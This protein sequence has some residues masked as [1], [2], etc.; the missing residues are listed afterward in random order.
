MILYSG[1]IS[2]LPK[3]IQTSLAFQI[4]SSLYST[5]YLYMSIPVFHLSLVLETF[6]EMESF[7]KTHL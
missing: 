7:V 6:V 4:L 2:F 3:L 5:Y 1:Y